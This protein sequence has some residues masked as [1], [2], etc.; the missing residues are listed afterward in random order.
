MSV[1]QNVS[2]VAGEGM[3]QQVTPKRRSMVAAVAAIALEGYDLA[4]YGIFAGVIARVFF[5]KDEAS[6]GLLLTV[7]TLGVGY[8]MRPLG[9]IVLGALGDKK[10]RRTAIVLTVVVM[11]LSTGLIGLVPSYQSIG[12]AAPCLVLVLRLCQGFAAGGAAGSSMAYLA[13]T[14]PPRLR[15]ML[16]SWQQSGQF[17]AFVIASGI[18]AAVNSWMSADLAQ[19]IGW[20]IPFVLALI[21]GP[22]GFWIQ[23]RLEE[24]T[25]NVRS[26]AAGEGTGEGREDKRQNIRGVLIGC[27]V[28]CLWSI[29]AFVLVIFMPTYANRNFAIPLSDAFLSGT[30]GGLLLFLLCP[31]MGRVSD[32][33]GRKPVMLV[34]AALIAL[35]IYPLFHYLAAA[36]GLGRL[37]QIQSVLALLIAIYIGP[38]AAFMAELFT[39]RRRST[40]L[41]I[42]YNLA[43]LLVGAFGPLITTWLIEFTHD[44]LAPAWYVAGGAAVS[45]VTLLFARDQTGREL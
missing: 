41:S 21:L 19:S 23:S 28:T 10:G 15:G 43:V 39:T 22:M 8:L 11:S 18:G 16:T 35:F 17:G 26:L 30:V 5:P 42:A 14:A 38:I 40:G 20:R 32:V 1:V 34:G 29:S 9:G 13:E 37:I 12:V 27:G 33:F 3:D 6:L 25:V 7:A 2:S 4:I 36:P 24:P 44:P 31:L 45:F